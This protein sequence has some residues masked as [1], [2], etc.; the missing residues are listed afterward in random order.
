MKPETLLLDGSPRKL[1]QGA[2]LKV[3]PVNNGDPS[4]SWQRKAVRQDHRRAA[5]WSAP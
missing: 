5:L 4:R 1:R 3:H 2:L